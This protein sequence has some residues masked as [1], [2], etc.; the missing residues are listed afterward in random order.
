MIT[1]SASRAFFWARFHFGRHLRK[2]GTWAWI[3][4][5]AFVAGLLR[6][7]GGSPTTIAN[8]VILYAVPLAAL[9][10]GTSAMREEI[11]DQTPTYVFTRPID[12]AW[13]YAARVAATIGVTMLIGAGGALFS[14]S[15]VTGGI[16]TFAA[17][18]GSAAAYTAF[19]AL[20]GALFKRPASFGLVFAIAWESGLGAVPGFL[21][22]LTL[23]T[24]LRNLAD[25][26]PT[27]AL[28]SALWSPPHLVVS[29]AVIIGVTAVALT[30]GG[31]L[32]R[33]REFVL[34][35]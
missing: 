9:S 17:A 12:R 4:G 27:N 25:L 6:A 16:R 3:G 24:H 26:R 18:V 14:V 8:L 30:I 33:T 21:T 31:I 15:S 7:F 22:Q 13:V 20:C 28:L 34:T 32:A 35:R 29:I 5:V 2:P 23:R 11:E 19:F 1:S 10:F